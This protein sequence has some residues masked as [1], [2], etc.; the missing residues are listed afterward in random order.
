VIDSGTEPVHVD[1]DCGREA[2]VLLH[3]EDIREGVDQ[4]K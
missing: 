4:K 1:M 2:G 3:F